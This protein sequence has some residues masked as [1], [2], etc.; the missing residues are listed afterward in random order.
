[1]ADFTP[2]VFNDGQPLDLD[3]LRKM[4][5]NLQ[6][7]Y[8]QINNVYAALTNGQSGN[9]ATLPV[10]DANYVTFSDGLK[11][12]TNGPK[13]FGFSVKFPGGAPYVIASISTNL[14]STLASAYVTTDA[15]NKYNI[16]VNSSAVVTSPVTVN[17]M[18]FAPKNIT[19]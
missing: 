2:V 18:A 10:V 4:A 12:G 19:V 16:Y 15:N 14:G 3:Q 17:W 9:T 11:K 6:A 5:T 7:M 13:S 8:T 1:M